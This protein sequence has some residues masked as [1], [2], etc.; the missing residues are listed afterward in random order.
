M[1]SLDSMM[2]ITERLKVSRLHPLSST[3]IYTNNLLFLLSSR[4]LT[5]EEKKISAPGEATGEVTK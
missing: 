5:R 2:L 1:C 4:P 3:D